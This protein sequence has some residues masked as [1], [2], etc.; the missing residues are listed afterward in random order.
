[1]EQQNKD[2]MIK[3]KSVNVGKNSKGGDHIKLSLSA[4]ETDFLIEQLQA[5]KT[6]RGARLDVHISDKTTQDGAREFKSGIAFV[7]G[8]QEYGSPKGSSERK[9]AASA[10]NTAMRER[11]QSLSKQTAPQLKK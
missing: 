5:S 1:M 4:E 2:P 11:V 9:P 6:E 8:I 10:G 7:R 3:F